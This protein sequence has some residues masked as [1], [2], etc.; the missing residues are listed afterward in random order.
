MMALTEEQVEEVERIVLGVLHGLVELSRDDT[1]GMGDDWA[2]FKDTL[3][4]EIDKIVRREAERS[5][6]GRA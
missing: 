6:L 5:W 1:W 4:N 2:G 3:K